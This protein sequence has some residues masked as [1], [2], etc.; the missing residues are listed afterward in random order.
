MSVIFGKTLQEHFEAAPRQDLRLP[1]IFRRGE[2]DNGRFLGRDEK[3]VGYIV[4]PAAAYTAFAGPD[5]ALCSYRIFDS[6]PVGETTLARLQKA[7]GAQ[8]A[9]FADRER[10]NAQAD[11]QNWKSQVECSD[12]ARAQPAA[13]WRRQAIGYDGIEQPRIQAHTSRP[14]I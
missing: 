7:A 1:D 12:F 3:P 5:A 14:A 8:L 13:L 6:F 2:R 11:L 9:I 10:A 4:L